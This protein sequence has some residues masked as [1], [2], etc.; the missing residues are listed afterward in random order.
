[1]EV[2]GHHQIGKIKI[3]EKDPRHLIMQKLVYMQVKDVI[4][5]E[6]R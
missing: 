5:Y 1:V 6:W 4:Q 2:T 3:V